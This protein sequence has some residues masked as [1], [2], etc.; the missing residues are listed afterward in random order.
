MLLS[1]EQSYGYFVNLYINILQANNSAPSSK[2]THKSLVDMCENICQRP[3]SNTLE[4]LLLRKKL[5][6]ER[7]YEMGIKDE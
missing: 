2:F 5:E 7:K 6:K 4:R 1:E 3:T